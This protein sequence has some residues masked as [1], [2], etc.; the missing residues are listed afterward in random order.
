MSAPM[1]KGMVDVSAKL[2]TAREAR[3]PTAGVVR[4]GGT[5][6]GTR[7]AAMPSPSRGSPGCRPSNAPPTSS[8]SRHPARPRRL[9]RSSSTTWAWRSGPRS[10]RPTGPGSRWRPHCRGRCSGPRRHVSAAVDLRHADHR[11][12]GHRQVWVGAPVIWWSWLFQR[13]APSG[14]HRRLHPGRRR[15]L[16]GPA[17]APPSSTPSPPGVCRHRPDRRPDGDPV[18]LALATARCDLT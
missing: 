6:R 1:R 17:P 3:P 10:A 18:G 4:S 9:R 12:P 8:G 7:P 11:D 15:H 2:I 5:A 13:P 14:G 16:R